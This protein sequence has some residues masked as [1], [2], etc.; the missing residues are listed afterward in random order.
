[1]GPARQ[2]L[3]TERSRGPWIA[4]GGLA[5][6]A[7]VF[8][9]AL[10]VLVG[11]QSG[12]HPEPAQVANEPARK[13]AAPARRSGL[14]EPVAERPAVQEKL[15]FY[16]TLTAPPV[17]LPVPAKADAGAKSPP[18]PAPADHAAPPAAAPSAPPSDKPSL[19]A[20]QPATAKPGES[21][22]A[23]WT[24]QVG[25]FK[26][27]GQAESVRR[28]LAS[29]GFD[30]YVIAVSGD[31]GQMRYKVR[32]GGFKTREDAARMAERMRQERALAAFVTQR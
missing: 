14:V 18:R 16:Q 10:G 19:A 30:V 21:R 23:D 4:L 12:R 13:P 26:E 25:A 5:L 1:M 8:T 31:D 29:G 27:R 24:V 2:R 6:V 32:V 28:P 17:P 9:F 7:L 20:G 22:Q 15:T 11:R 3:R